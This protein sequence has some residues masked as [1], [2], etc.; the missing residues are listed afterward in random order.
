MKGRC[1]EAGSDSD[2]H[3]Y[4]DFLAEEPLL[5]INRC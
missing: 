4:S 1:G 5:N 2:D 3:N